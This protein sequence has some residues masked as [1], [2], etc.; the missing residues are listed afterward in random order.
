MSLELMMFTVLLLLVAFVLTIVGALYLG[1]KLLKLY[2]AVTDSEA[3]GSTKTVFWLAAL[4]LVSPID[5]LPDPILIDDIIALLAA[6][7]HI[8]SKTSQ[9]G[10]VEE[11]GEQPGKLSDRR[12]AE[13][14]RPAR[15]P[16]TPSTS[17]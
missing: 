15:E 8:S 12:Y 10:E 9:P 16:D 4:Y 3:P 13:I 17:Q 14:D 6:I 2:P 1:Y 5:I 11:G 7:S